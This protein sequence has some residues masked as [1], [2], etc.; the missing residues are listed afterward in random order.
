MFQLPNFLRKNYQ[1]YLI[2]YSKKVYNLFI[3]K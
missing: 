3:K 2:S 1:K